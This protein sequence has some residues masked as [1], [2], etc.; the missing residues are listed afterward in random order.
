MRRLIFATLA[1]ALPHAAGAQEPAPPEPFAEYFKNADSPE[2]AQQL[3][4]ILQRTKYGPEAVPALRALLESDAPGRVRGAAVAAIGRV[5]QRGE[6]AYPSALL[7]AAFDRHWFV[8]ANALATV[9]VMK[10]HPKGA[11]T[12]LLPF[13]KD[14][15]Y[16]QRGDAMILLARVGKGDPKAI[17]AIKAGRE[18][19]H[20]FVRHSAHFALYEA[21][22]DLGEFVPY[23]VRTA[24]SAESKANK[25]IPEDAPEEVRQ[26]AAQR[27]LCILAC[28]MELLELAER[29]PERFV[30]VLHQL[31]QDESAQFRE[32]TVLAIRQV[33][34]T[35]VETAKIPP[36]ASPDIFEEPKPK[37]ATP[38]ELVKEHFVSGNGFTERLKKMRAADPDAAIR[39]A[40]TRA[41]KAF[42]EA[43]TAKPAEPEALLK[44]MFLPAGS[45]WEDSPILRQPGIARW[46]ASGERAGNVWLAEGV[47]WNWF[48]QSYE[49]EGKT[50]GGTTWLFGDGT[51]TPKS[52][53]VPRSPDE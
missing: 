13:T 36:V 27:N 3:E 20:F 14:E 19:Q 18:D 15:R 24:A 37:E 16:H 26:S 2:A 52:S 43:R 46:P 1:L 47:K 23:L 45:A 44:P 7:E 22:S 17:A 8:R 4:M 21:T 48:T 38:L 34:S 12:V 35:A 49:Y 9:G 11:V 53:A 39:E 5:F 30:A 10:V 31:L 28:S 50:A 32:D 41:L 29:G 51:V 40:A 25:P 6:K 33:V 42:A